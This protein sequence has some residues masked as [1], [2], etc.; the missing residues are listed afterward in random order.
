MDLFDYFNEKNNN[1]IHTFSSFFPDKFTATNA[2]EIWDNF[3]KFTLAD[4]N[5]VIAWH[6]LLIKYIFESED[7][8]H[9]CRL[10][11]SGGHK[12]KNGIQ[13]DEI[14]R[15]ALTIDGNTK[16]MFVSNYDAAEMFNIVL[17]NI[18]ADL[19]LFIKMINDKTYKFHYQKTSP[20]PLKKD[21][22]TYNA[23]KVLPNNF[24]SK[25]IQEEFYILSGYPC[26][27]SVKGSVLNQSNRY[28]AHI[29]GIKDIPYLLPSGKIITGAR[30][31]EILPKGN[32]I[33][34][35]DTPNSIRKINTNLSED[36]I[37][38]LKAH[39]L[40]FFDPLNYF[41]TPS[42]KCHIIDNKS[43]SNKNI[44]EYWKVQK[45]VEEQYEEIYGKDKLDE[46]R[47]YALVPDFNHKFKRYQDK[48]KD[49]ISFN[50]VEIGKNIKNNTTNPQKIKK[51][52]KIKIIYQYI[53]K[54]ITQYN[55]KSI[56]EL[57]HEFPC[58]S[59]LSNQIKDET[60]Y[61][62]EDIILP[63]DDRIRITNQIGD[64]DNFSENRNFSKLIEK[65]KKLGIVINN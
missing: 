1:K 3:I 42:N 18:P 63:N 56:D 39:F 47:K 4:K 15:T 45:Y 59:K 17:K 7:P 65:F 29:I 40:R 58:I 22:L 50:K 27:G 19:N 55:V 48:T 24:T 53:K 49:L 16:Y 44:G 6:D 26:I 41:A 43:S 37:K 34:W 14:R 8:I 9:F 21:Y 61:F 13:I 32:I 25:S 35:S 11:E 12:D 54:Y 28:L 23:D 62:K 2:K 57:N 10:Y 36:D 60:R 30:L 33:D 31:K 20:V 51:I 46:F 38:V 64:K 5:S 52:S